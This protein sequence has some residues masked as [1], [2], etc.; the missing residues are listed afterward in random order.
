MKAT[1]PTG[2]LTQKTACQLKLVTRKPPRVGPVTE[3]TPAT[4]PQ[5]P[6]A[7]P[8]RLGGKMFVR[9]LRVCGVRMAPPMPWTM[10]ATMSWPGLCARL[11]PMDAKVK[12]ASP[13]RKSRLAPYLS[14]SRPAV[15][16][17]TA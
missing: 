6:N 17:N 5:T 2:T 8:R 14:P 9:M 12:T 4:A 10:R 11:Q 7:A 15:I 3:A 16:S 13:T 1:T